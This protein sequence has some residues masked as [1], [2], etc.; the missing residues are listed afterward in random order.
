[1]GDRSNSRDVTASEIAA[2]K[3]RDVCNRRV[4]DATAARLTRVLVIVG[5]RDG[6]AAG[7]LMGPWSLS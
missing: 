1:M 7:K 3:S 4:T 2:R 5:G 6:H